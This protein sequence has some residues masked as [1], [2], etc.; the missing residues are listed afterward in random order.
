MWV[1]V[2][3]SENVV[4]VV[5]PSAPAL[6]SVRPMLPPARLDAS[7][8]GGRHGAGLHLH[9][10]RA[11]GVTLTALLPSALAQPVVADPSLYPF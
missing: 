6:L 11:S 4:P 3:V 5:P 8:D 2:V 10:A 1:S 7:P 9:R